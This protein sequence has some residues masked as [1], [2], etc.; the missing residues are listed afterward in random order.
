MV[1]SG[2]RSFLQC[3]VWWARDWFVANCGGC[4]AVI[5]GDARRLLAGRE[6]VCADAR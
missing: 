5:G 4:W 6:L 2:I 3:L 1:L